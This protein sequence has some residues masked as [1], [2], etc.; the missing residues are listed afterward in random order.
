MIRKVGLEWRGKKG[1]L[2]WDEDLPEDFEV[3]F[4]GS[5]RIFGKVIDYLL[6]EHEYKIGVSPRIDDYVIVRTL[7]I[8]NMHFF[9]MALSEMS[10]KI[11]VSVE[12]DRYTKKR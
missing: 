11:G 6:E 5:R 3:Y 4:P 8:E 9:S 2:E 1:Y 10:A 12:W 7:P